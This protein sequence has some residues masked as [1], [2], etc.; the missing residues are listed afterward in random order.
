MLIIDYDDNAL[1]IMEQVNDEL[2]EYGLEFVED[3]EKNEQAFKDGSGRMFY[4][5]E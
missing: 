4:N 5:L 3:N 1:D 2:A